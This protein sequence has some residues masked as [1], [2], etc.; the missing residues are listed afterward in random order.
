MNSLHMW[1][2]ASSFEETQLHIIIKTP[3]ILLFILQIGRVYKEHRYCKQPS[4]GV[5]V[6]SSIVYEAHAKHLATLLQHAT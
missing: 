2:K 1:A 5:D 3:Q 6:L 4:K